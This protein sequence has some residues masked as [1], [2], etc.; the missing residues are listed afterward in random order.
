V[1][2]PVSIYLGCLLPTAFD[3]AL[4]C[5]A[6]CCGIKWG[7]RDVSHVEESVR[8]QLDAACEKWKEKTCKRIQ[9]NYELRVTSCPIRRIK[10]CRVKEPSVSELLG[11]EL[12]HKAT[13]FVVWV[14]LPD[15]TFPALGAQAPYTKGDYMWIPTTEER[16][17]KDPPR[18]A[19]SHE[20][21]HWVK[22][23]MKDI[24]VCIP[25]PDGKDKKEYWP[26]LQEALTA[27]NIAKLNEEIAERKRKRAARSAASPDEPGAV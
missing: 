23:R 13:C 3:I 15:C 25:S 27:G 20:L 7:I 4:T 9:V 5:Q 19:A 26:K 1:D 18:D 2:E 17:L 6:G 11:A 14:P 8:R 10:D 21:K 24:G 22:N 16:E 12:Y